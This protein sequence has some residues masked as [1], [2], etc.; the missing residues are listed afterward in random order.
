VTKT[1][2][3]TDFSFI[4]VI[5]PPNLITH[6]IPLLLSLR[7]HHPDTPIYPYAPLGKA[8][9]VPDRVK[10]IHAAMNAPI[11]TLSRELAFSMNRYQKPYHHGHKLLAVAENRPHAFCVFVDTDT[12]LRKPLNDPTLFQH[13]KIAAVPES[14]AGYAQRFMDVWEETYAI[15][16]LPL[17]DE[18]VKMLRTNR[19]TA[20]YYNAGF[21]AFPETVPDGTRFGA[22]WLETALTLDFD[23]RIDDE[24]KRP[25]LDQASLPVAVYRSGCRFETLTPAFNYPIDGTMFPANDDAVLYHYHGFERLEAAESMHEIEDLLLASGRFA[26]FE[27]FCTP[28]N[29]RRNAINAIMRQVAGLAE[30]R[31]SLKPQ[32]VA[33]KGKGPSD[34]SKSLNVQMLEAR[35]KNHELRQSLTD[36]TEDNFYDETWG[37]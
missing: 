23:Q 9:Q 15:F 14:V 32:I 17:P 26:S 33:L 20:P 2:G 24:R 36:V 21:V 12:L 25:W 34:A 8:D 13:D 18:R 35:R 7:R 1:T 3:S 22:R 27:H 4:Y 29:M 10:A 5:D 28:L 19:E 16:D 6:A 11:Q 31:R 30:L 37:V